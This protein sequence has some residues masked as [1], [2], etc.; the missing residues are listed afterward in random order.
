MHSECDC[1]FE[2]VRVYGYVGNHRHIASTDVQ[3]L[4]ANVEINI[5]LERIYTIETHGL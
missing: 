1:E 4:M 3:K 5:L 2:G